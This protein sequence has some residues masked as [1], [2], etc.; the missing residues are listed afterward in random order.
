MLAAK[1]TFSQNSHVLARMASLKK[2]GGSFGGHNQPSSV[3]QTLNSA[4]RFSYGHAEDSNVS[5]STLPSLSSSLPAPIS[6]PDEEFPAL[7][8]GRTWPSSTIGDSTNPDA[9]PRRGSVKH[10]AA[11]SFSRLHTQVVPSTLPK[12]LSNARSSRQIHRGVDQDD[13]WS[14]G[15]DE[16]VV[17]PRRVSSKGN[18]KGLAQK[19]AADVGVGEKGT[20]ASQDRIYFLGRLLTSILRHRATDLNLQVRDDGYVV[21]TDLLKLGVKTRAGIP[22]SVYTVDDILKAVERDDKQRFSLLTENGVLLIRANQGHSIKTI[23]SDKLLK[24]IHSSDEIPVCVHGTYMRN[25]S[26]ILKTGLKKMGRNHV[27]FA[28]GL[29]REDGVISGMRYTSEV[30]IYLDSKKAL[31][32][33]MKLYMSDNGVILTEGF[34]GVVPPEYFAKIAKWNNGKITPLPLDVKRESV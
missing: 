25:L 16:D 2:V 4:A 7:G 6:L 34:D 31:E 30:F 19:K 28:S 17:L 23:E 8:N 27:H 33:G 26:S 29:P 10:P 3:T 1:S 22:L 15:A 32:D 21:V 24:P 20:S 9:V 14:L 18:R 5:N 12:S 13:D 11:G